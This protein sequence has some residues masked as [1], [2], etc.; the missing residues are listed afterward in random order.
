[1]TT[2]NCRMER[3]NVIRCTRKC[4]SILCSNV[5]QTNMKEARP[6]LYAK[7]EAENQLVKP[8]LNGEGFSFPAVDKMIEDNGWV[9]PIELKHQD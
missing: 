3:N 2:R 4:R 9:C 8:E 6:E 7:I 5:D 1:M